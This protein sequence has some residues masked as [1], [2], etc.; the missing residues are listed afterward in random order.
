[1]YGGERDA[2]ASI[3]YSLD[4]IGRFEEDE[5]RLKADKEGKSLG[6]GLAIEKWRVSTRSD[7][8]KT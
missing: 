7:E 1:M 2:P 6:C 3:V 8:E 5:L 4:G